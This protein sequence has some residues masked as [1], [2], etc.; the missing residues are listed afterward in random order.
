MKLLIVFALIGS[1][2]LVGCSEVDNN[3]GS[4]TDNAIMNASHRVELT[5]SGMDCGGCTGQV[6]AAV[7]KV[8]GFT[9]AVADLESGKVT[10]ALEDSADTDTAKAE[11]EK[12]VT[13]LSKG[14]YTIDDI[15]AIVPD[16]QTPSDNATPE[17]SQDVNESA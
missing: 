10:I 3:A 4:D 13:G 6:C 11:I 16:T 12:I 5:V 17:P 1:M 14:K 7:E 2:A 9:G 15:Q 8:P